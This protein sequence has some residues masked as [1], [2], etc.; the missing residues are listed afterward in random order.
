MQKRM[1]MRALREIER[2]RKDGILEENQVERVGEAP[3]TCLFS[4]TLPQYPNAVRLS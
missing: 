2:A 4:F 1:S 3:F